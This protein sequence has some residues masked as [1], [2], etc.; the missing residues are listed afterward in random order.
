MADALP[1][2]AGALVSDIFSQSDH[3]I[4]IEIRTILA[5]VRH[6][7]DWIEVTTRTLEMRVVKLEDTINGGELLSWV[8]DFRSGLKAYIAF[9][10][11][12]STFLGWLVTLGVHYLVK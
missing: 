2:R 11:G 3:D 10:L 7:V 5:E 1:G 12:A 4:L 8:R 6:K 9:G